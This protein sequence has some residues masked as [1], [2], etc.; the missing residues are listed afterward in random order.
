MSGLAYFDVFTTVSSW[1]GEEYITDGE[2]LLYENNKRVTFMDF[3]DLPRRTDQ[4]IELAL[5]FGDDEAEETAR[6]ERHGWHVIHAREASDSPQKYKH[7]I[8]HSRG[9]FSCVKPSCIRFQNGWISD[10]T[11]CYMASGKPVVYQNTGPSNFLPEGHGLFRFTTVDEA[12]KAFSEINRHYESH[13][14][15]A[16]DLVEEYFD[17][18]QAIDT[19][20][21]TAL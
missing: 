19:I 4:K 20:L 16:R 12:V 2:D 8:Q 3:D 18:R 11:L 5:S 15:A 6:L 10:R 13:C 17:S 21:T 7:Y 9:E 14:R 1:W